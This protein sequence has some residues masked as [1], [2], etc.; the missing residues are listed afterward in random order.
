MESMVA[1]LQEIIDRNLVSLSI[2][3][4]RRYGITEKPTPLLLLALHK[5]YGDPFLNDMSVAIDKDVLDNFGP[6]ES[7]SSTTD[8][9]TKV[10]LFNRLKGL[11]DKAKPLLS[12]VTGSKSSSSNQTQK[13]SGVDNQ[14]KENP[15]KKIII[16]GAIVIVVLIVVVVIIK[17]FKK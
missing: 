12:T 8:G 3:L 9:T 10:S 2:F 5:R 11:F 6:D 7:T 13:G 17:R 14:P 1:E 16:I 15:T 4:Q